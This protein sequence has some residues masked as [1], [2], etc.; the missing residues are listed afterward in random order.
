MTDDDPA[1]DPWHWRFDF[2]CHPPPNPRCPLKTTETK[3]INLYVTSM[4]EQ[5]QIL[6]TN[7]SSA[8]PQD[9]CEYDHLKHFQTEDCEHLKG[10][11]AFVVVTFLRGST[12]I[13]I[14][15]T[16]KE[17]KILIRVETPKAAA[18]YVIGKYGWG[19]GRIPLVAENDP[20]V[21]WFK[22]EAIEEDVY[23]FQDRVCKL[24]E[25]YA[26]DPNTE[27]NTEGMTRIPCTA[28][29]DFYCHDY[30]WRDDQGKKGYRGCNFDPNQI[31]M[32]PRNYGYREISTTNLVPGCIVTY[33]KTNADVADHSALVIGEDAEGPILMSKDV[34]NSI[35]RH[36]LGGSM[37]YFR[38]YF[39]KLQLRFFRK[40]TTDEMVAG[41][42]S[43]Q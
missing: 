1:R 30:A 20:R 41:S 5:G 27:T 43:I 9:Y 8:T 42:G 21:I 6:F 23:V 17:V 3:T 36:R 24:H 4:N 22:K 37:N 35:F 19:L 25:F 38:D 33:H 34:Q 32:T 29:K 7:A 16:G 39:G 11:G 31:L 14:S 28:S 40:L 18:E 26:F 13:P 15:D 10:D 12:P 2:T